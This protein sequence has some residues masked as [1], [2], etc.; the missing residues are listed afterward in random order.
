MLAAKS[1]EALEVG[2]VSNADT[3]G[4]LESSMPV[5]ESAEAVEVGV[6]N[7]AGTTSVLESSMPVAESAEALQVGFLNN[8]ETTDVLKNTTPGAESAEAVEAG[9]VN[10]AEITDTLVENAM[11]AAE[12]TEAVEIALVNDAKTTDILKYAHAECI[13][14]SEQ[15]SSTG[16]L[17][18]SPERS[19]G[20]TF[21]QEAPSSLQSPI[22][23]AVVASCPNSHKGE[24]ASLCRASRLAYSFLQ[25]SASG[26]ISAWRART[27]SAVVTLV[28]TSQ[29]SVNSAALYFLGRGAPWEMGEATVCADCIRDELSQPH[30]SVQAHWVSV[31]KF[32]DIITKNA[33]RV[34]V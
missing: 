32:K 34:S 33:S 20:L 4:V 6:I 3:P 14:S 16:L 31:E 23:V 9:V 24:V 26:G 2:V 22:T 19:D 25:A 10:N 27:V 13:S 11:P 21:P 15:N 17:D 8:S 29:V 7:S 30:F 18:G 1:A 12:S 28:A 5:A